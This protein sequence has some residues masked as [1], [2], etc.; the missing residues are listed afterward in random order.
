MT[1]EEHKQLA[2]KAERQANILLG[3]YLGLLSLAGFIMS[4]KADSG[5]LFWV[6]VGVVSCVIL[7]IADIIRF[8]SKIHTERAHRQELE[9]QH[10]RF[11]EHLKDARCARCDQPT[12][13]HVK[14]PDY[15]GYVG[16]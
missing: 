14:A 16:P 7:P 8:G 4:I 6:I 5:L 10:Q 13:G 11:M 3:A 2:E 15:E 1:T 9:K 12:Q